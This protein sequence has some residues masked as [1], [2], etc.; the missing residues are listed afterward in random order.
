VHHNRRKSQPNL[1]DTMNSGRFDR[2]TEVSYCVPSLHFVLRDDNLA[3][4]FSACMHAWV[5]LP[6]LTWK[7]NSAVRFILYPPYVNHIYTHMH[8]YTPTVVPC[9]VSV[10]YSTL[11]STLSYLCGAI[12]FDQ[13]ISIDLIQS[14]RH[15]THASSL[16]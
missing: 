5:T 9:S 11:G 7:R 4:W 13:H 12:C 3:S 2:L 14:Q 6:P 1:A 10:G 15:T 16:F 8:I